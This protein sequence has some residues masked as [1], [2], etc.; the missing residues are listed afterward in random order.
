MCE[1]GNDLKIVIPVLA[2][3]YCKRP[4][5]FWGGR[6]EHEGKGRGVVACVRVC[7][8]SFDPWFAIFV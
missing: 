1:A 6:S 7:T 4:S 5:S 8:Q 3:S 2:E